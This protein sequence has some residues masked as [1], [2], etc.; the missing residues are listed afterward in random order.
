MSE[1][2]FK[3][4]LIQTQDATILE[5][6]ALN[7]YFVCISFFRKELNPLFLKWSKVHFLNKWENL[8]LPHSPQKKYVILN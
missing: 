1:L 5:Y 4:V 2:R 6:S 7:Y 8:L 3:Y